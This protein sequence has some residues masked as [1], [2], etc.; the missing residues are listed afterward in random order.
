ME[1][2]AEERQTPDEVNMRKPKKN[3]VKRWFASS[4]DDTMLG[5]VQNACQFA[6]RLDPEGSSERALTMLQDIEATSNVLE[7]NTQV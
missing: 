7:R 6:S 2:R 5:H 4:A 3:N 1:G